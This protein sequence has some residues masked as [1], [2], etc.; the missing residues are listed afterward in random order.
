MV[1][2]RCP[3]SDGANGAEPG[4][5]LE[6]RRH[7]SEMDRDTPGRHDWLWGGPEPHT[8]GAIRTPGARAPR[9]ALPPTEDSRVFTA[10]AL[11]AQS[12]RQSRH[13]SERSQVGDDQCRFLH[14]E[15]IGHWRRGLYRLGGRESDLS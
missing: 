2:D 5:A 7:R 8:D 1:L 3:G 4:R 9:G 12:P 10:S 15:L 13:L 6:M 14:A 11:N